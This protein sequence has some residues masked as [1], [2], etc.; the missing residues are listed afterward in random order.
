M[1]WSVPVAMAVLS[2]VAKPGRIRVKRVDRY[3]PCA[4]G[5]VQPHCSVLWGF[6]A[7]GGRISGKEGSSGIGDGCVIAGEDMSP[8]TGAAATRD[9]DS[10]RASHAAVAARPCC[11]RRNNI[12][13]RI[14][15]RIRKRIQKYFRV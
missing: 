6:F 7:G 15:L 9:G 5:E 4:L 1:A 14:F 3:L 2:M 10:A 11:L 8:P 12:Q 13:K